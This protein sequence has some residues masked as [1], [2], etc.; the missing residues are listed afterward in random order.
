MSGWVAR[1]LED[2]P[3]VAG[4]GDLVWHPLQHAFGLTAF[5][6]NAFVARESGVSLVEEH[7]EAE[8]G[9]EELYLVVRGAATFVLDGKEV[10]A[11]AIT[12]VAV[13]SPSVRRAAV[14]REPGTILLAL[15]G[16][17]REAFDST[18]N[19]EHFEGVPRL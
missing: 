9:Q 1:R 2:V 13:R 11:P 4:V 15:G 8:S 10:D 3:R 12:A 19:D 6:A 16:P 7:D 18:W 5:G 17:A 14:A